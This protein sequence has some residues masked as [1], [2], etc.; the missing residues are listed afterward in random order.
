M[1]NTIQ[2]FIIQLLY[3]NSL[4]YSSLDDMNLQD[5]AENEKPMSVMSVD[6]I[7]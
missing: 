2:I 7:V 4:I 1:A 5:M 6:E 3:Q